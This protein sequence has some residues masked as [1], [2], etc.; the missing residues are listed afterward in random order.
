VGG[1][2]AADEAGVG[3]GRPDGRLDEHH[4]GVVT[5]SEE[6]LGEMRHGAD[7]AGATDAGAQNDGLLQG[8]AGVHASDG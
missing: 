3:V 5:V 4:G 1:G 2:D 7:V 6:E 8:I